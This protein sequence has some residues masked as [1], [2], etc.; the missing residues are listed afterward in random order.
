MRIQKLLSIALLYFTY[1]SL[2]C[3]QSSTDQVF[4]IIN[5]SSKLV[6][7][8]KIKTEV[9]VYSNMKS[10]S[11]IQEIPLKE[12]IYGNKFKLE[13]TNFN[14]KI[15]IIL[16]KTDKKLEDFLKEYHDKK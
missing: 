2:F 9:A 4:I 11:Y 16:V 7:E 1:N 10:F 3:A 12:L 5:D 13:K 15:Y 14:G 6:S 8:D